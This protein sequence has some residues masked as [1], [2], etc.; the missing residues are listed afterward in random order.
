[1]YLRLLSPCLVFGRIKCLILTHIN[2]AST[3]PGV[4][5]NLPRIWGRLMQVEWFHITYNSQNTT[6]LVILCNAYFWKWYNLE[7]VHPMRICENNTVFAKSDF[8]SKTRHPAPVSPT[9]CVGVR[10]CMCVR[11]RYAYPIE[12]DTCASL[13]FLTII[14]FESCVVCWWCAV[15]VA[16]LHP[17]MSLVVRR[18]SDDA[19]I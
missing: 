5:V 1:M 9:V 17:V 13:L 7:C 18:E 3:Y 19:C 16:C 14:R 10:V 8:W 4:R 11:V 12:R 15:Q 2:G 6:L